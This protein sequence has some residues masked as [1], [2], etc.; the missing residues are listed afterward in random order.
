MLALDTLANW[1][2]VADRAV[3]FAMRLMRA[4]GVTKNETVLSVAVLEPVIPA[5]LLPQPHEEV[6]IA[7]PMLALDI[8][9][10]PDFVRARSGQALNNRKRIG[11]QHGVR[12]VLDAHVLKQTA[13]LIQRREMQP[14]A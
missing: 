5:P 7:F 1:R 2:E 8:A 12:D 11:G 10:R 4:N 6:V 13:V 3:C 14:R 9:L